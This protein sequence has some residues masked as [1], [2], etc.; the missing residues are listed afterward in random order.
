MLCH[1]Q[2][3]SSF[4]KKLLPP[5]LK[6]KSKVPKATKSKAPT[7]RKRESS[8][9]L[10]EFNDSEVELDPLGLLFMQL[11]DDDYSQEQAETSH[12]DAV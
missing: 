12:A 5:T 8:K 7:R 3:G 10:F 4:W 1:A 6:K 2:A 11:I 9:D